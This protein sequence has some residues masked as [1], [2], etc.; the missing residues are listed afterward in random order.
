MDASHK[1]KREDFSTG[2]G[3]AVCPSKKLDRAT[4]EAHLARTSGPEYWRSLEELAGSP[5][6]QEMLHREF[7]KGASEWVESFSRRGFLQ[8]MGASLALAGMTGCTKL[9]LEPIVPYVR[10]PEDVIPG[11]PMFFASAAQPRLKATTGI[12]RV[13]VEPTSLRRRRFLG[14]TTPTARRPSCIWVM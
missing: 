12:P 8:L 13:S 6:F 7:P 10:Q 4:V 11:R 5:E 1:T 3:P 14:C 9:P 2:S